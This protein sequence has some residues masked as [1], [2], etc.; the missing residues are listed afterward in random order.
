MWFGA[1]E[2]I[3]GGIDKAIERALQ[4][5]CDALQVFTKS[6]NQWKARPLSD[7]E[8]EAFQRRW[9]ESGLRIVV[10]H[11]SYL[12]NLASPDD[13][14]WEKSIA[15]FREE[16]ERCERLGIPYL[17]THPGAYGTS[18]LEEG[19]RRIAEALNRVHA[20]LPGYRV[21]TLLETTAGQGT[22][23]GARFEELAAITERIREP[24]R[25]AY[26]FDTCHVFAAGYELT[27]PDGY[28]QTM[29]E[30]DNVL[31]LDRLRVFHLND[32]KRERGSRVDRHEHIGKGKIG[33]E[34]FRQLVND[35]RFQHHPALLETEKSQDLHEDRENLQVLRSL[36]Q[37]VSD[38][39]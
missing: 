37:Q 12:I 13:A 7:A 3:A 17:V 19:I 25:I 29:A 30:F 39:Q 38:G 6:S 28:A 18:S 27:T 2:S 5:G 35:P 26:C 10:A 4:V 16:L 24:E 21:V 32:S 11:D 36:V 14:L 20:E 22:T 23:I 31:G 1:H 33:L 9:Q 8:V 34:G 15:A